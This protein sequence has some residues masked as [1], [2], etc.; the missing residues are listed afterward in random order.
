MQNFSLIFLLVVWV[1]SDAFLY[2]PHST[3]DHASGC[4]LH[5]DPWLSAG[6]FDCAAGIFSVTGNGELGALLSW[7]FVEYGNPPQFA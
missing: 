3:I 2:V 5:G 1:V 6:Q 4:S 7:L